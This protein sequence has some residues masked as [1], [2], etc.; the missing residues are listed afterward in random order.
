MSTA[1]SA[2]VPKALKERARKHGVVIS[3]FVRKA[4]EA[5]VERLERDELRGE[6]HEIRQRLKGKLGERD[7]VKAIRESREER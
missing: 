1:V 6:L 5:E 3:E 4:L 7:V 2:K